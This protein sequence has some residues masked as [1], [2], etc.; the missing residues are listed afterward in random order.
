LRPFQILS[1]VFLV[2]P[3]EEVLME[4]IDRETQRYMAMV[5]ALPVLTKEEELQLAERYKSGADRRAADRLITSNLRNVVPMALRY[6]RYG[7]PI[8][9]LIAEGNAAL[10][11]TLDRFEPQ[12]GL[13]FATY[14]NYWVRA[15][16][17]ACVLRARSMVDGGRGRLRPKYF[18]RLRREHARLL[19]L[20]GD[21]NTVHLLLAESFGLDVEEV[22]AVLQRL[23]QPDGSL[24]VRVGED[25]KAALV[26]TLASGD[27]DQEQA[28]VRAR[29]RSWLCAAVAEA[30][31]DLDER[32][33]RIVR[34]RLMA[35]PEQERSLVE[36]GREFGVSRERA[37]QLETRVKS[38]LR[39]RLTAT[40]AAMSSSD[41]L[42][43]CP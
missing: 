1:R 12:R 29:E 10:M 21:P 38:K 39:A 16:M 33:S 43:T 20:V 8:S 4:A 24:D 18:F 6:R 35:D 34:E 22:R 5:K 36:L 3:T 41:Y 19:G 13:R 9:E 37:R 15:E 26:D 23:E 17:L 2:S 42:T 27:G 31:A 30:T 28:L 25:Q 11:L 7:L 32:E 14:A 40:A